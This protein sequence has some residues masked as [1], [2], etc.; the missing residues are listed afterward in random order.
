MKGETESLKKKTKDAIDSMKDMTSAEILMARTG[1]VDLELSTRTYN[2]LIR[3]FNNN[4]PS[5]YDVSKLSYQDL[6]SVRNM[7]RR[8]IEEL[9]KCFREKF[10]YAFTTS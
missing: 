4:N 7:G 1:L 9:T 2:C 3:H 6:C 10:G 8:S 5:A